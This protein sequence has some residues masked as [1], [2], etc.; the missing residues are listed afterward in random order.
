[1]KKR[2]KLPLTFY[3]SPA[4]LKYPKYVHVKAHITH[5]RKK[6]G[7]WIFVLSYSDLVEVVESYRD[8]A[9][10]GHWQVWVSDF[11]NTGKLLSKTRRKV[12]SVS[13]TTFYQCYEKLWK[14]NTSKPGEVDLKNTLDC[15]IVEV[16]LLVRKNR[17]RGGLK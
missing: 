11:S 1:M 4:S 7:L 2:L 16:D 17:Q 14:W 9:Y 12:T 8:G 10:N 15:R 3:L 5:K 13:F 6:T